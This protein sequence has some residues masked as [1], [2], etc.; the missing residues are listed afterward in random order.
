MKMVQVY[1]QEKDI[2]DIDFLIKRKIYPHRAELI[3]LAVRD[4]LYKHGIL[5]GIIQK[6]NRKH[7]G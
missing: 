6:H 3:R 1:L 5:P 7:E 2:A 4:L